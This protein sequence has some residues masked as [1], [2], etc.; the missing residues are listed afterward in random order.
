MQKVLLFYKKCYNYSC[1]KERKLEVKVLT[2]DFLDA[3]VYVAKENGDCLIIDSGA[4]LEDVKEAVG[5][6]RVV[7]ILLT[8][9][10]FDHSC[11]CNEYAREFNVK[12]YANE[13]IKTTMT[14]SVAIYSE[15]YS[16]IDDFSRFEFIKGD[17]KL[18]I[19]NFD[20][21]CYYCPGHSIC[22]ECYVIDNIM[23]SGDVLFEN[24]IG[25]TDLKNSDKKQMFESLS[26][27]E[28]VKFEKV[29]SGHDGSSDYAF[30]MKNIKVFK[31]FLSR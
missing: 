26:K 3:K 9:G 1:F 5:E 30:Q 11:H 18:K 17:P 16:T 21:S 8:H 29:Y 25:R 27:L 13:H 31:R 24:G 15:D 7:G 6:D 14:D 2:G 28:N 20:I 23:F 22:C 4:K 19:S 12:I 10:H